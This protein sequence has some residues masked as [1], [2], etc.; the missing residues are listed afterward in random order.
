MSSG[1]ILEEMKNSVE[2]NAQLASVKMAKDIREMKKAAAD[3]IAEIKK[4]VSEQA[5]IYGAKPQ[6]TTEV[7]SGY[8]KQ[9]ENLENVYLNGRIKLEKARQRVEILETKATE[10]V[11]VLKKQ[12]KE[13]KGSEQ[14]KS[15]KKTYDVYVKEAKEIAKTGN[16]TEYYKKMDEV[17]RMEKE[18]PTYAKQIEIEKGKK[19]ITRARNLIKQKELKQDILKNNVKKCISKATVQKSMAIIKAEKRNAF[20]K[21]ITS[22]FNK[23][24]GRKKFKDRVIAPM[25]EGINKFRDEVLPGY[26][27]NVML[28]VDDKIEN[29][30]DRAQYISEKMSQLIKDGKSAKDKVISK[31]EGKIREGN[32]NVRTRINMLKNDGPTLEGK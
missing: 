7:V 18:N 11:A 1:K 8:E 26:I 15:W 21:V 30:T 6:E 13:I 32:N 17:R 28:V 29:A 3:K 2:L 20:Q 4:Y 22:I 9:I 19:Y 10:R 14:Y 27:E 16:T 23:V 25:K 5:K 24:N 12:V 31:M